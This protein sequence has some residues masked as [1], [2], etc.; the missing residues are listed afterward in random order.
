MATRSPIPDRIA[1]RYRRAP[2]PRPYWPGLALLTA[3]FVPGL[4]QRPASLKLVVSLNG[5]PVEG[6]K[7]YLERHP[8]KGTSWD[9]WWP[10]RSGSTD[11]QGSALFFDLEPGVPYSAQIRASSSDPFDSLR[12]THPASRSM[13]TLSAGRQSRSIQLPSTTLDFAISG[14]EANDHY[15]SHIEAYLISF[16]R[17]RASAVA[18]L[19][20]EFSFSEQDEWVQYLLWTSHH[21]A[22]GGLHDRLQECSQW[23]R[24]TDPIAKSSFECVPAGAYLLVAFH[25]LTDE[26][27]RTKRV[28]QGISEVIQVDGIGNASFEPLTLEQ[29][30]PV[31]VLVDGLPDRDADVSLTLSAIRLGQDRAEDDDMYFDENE[32]VELRVPAGEYHLVLW[33]DDAILEQSHVFQV[34][35]REP[36]KWSITPK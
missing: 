7:V 22:P 26:S 13:F 20:T 27:G 18:S 4:C 8:L 32:P 36:V 1:R 14:F 17:D 3:L 31:Q 5:E 33:A 30:F 21:R 23:L 11:S 15:G 29:V 16:H 19:D 10:T 9:D 12:D 2:R 25:Y 28:A 24:T 6:A 34:P 35:C